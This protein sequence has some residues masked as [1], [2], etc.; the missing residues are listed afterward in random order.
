MAGRSKYTLGEE[1]GCDVLY[2]KQL[3]FHRLLECA[4]SLLVSGT[5]LSSNVLQLLQLLK[6]W[7]PVHAHT[8]TPTGRCGEGGREG[9]RGRGLPC[10][11]PDLVV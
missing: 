9:G 4:I 7:V 1:C 10:V 11:G 2:L 8:Y 6:F 3:S 5:E